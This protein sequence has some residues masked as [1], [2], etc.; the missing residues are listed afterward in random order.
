[1]L[2]A[3]LVATILI[4]L[5]E[6]GDKT[7]LLALVL[8]CRYKPGQVLLG[9]FGATLLIHLLSTLVGAAVGSFVPQTV[10]TW[11]AGLLFVGFGIWTLRGDSV[12]EDAE[13][14]PSRFGPVV[15]SGIAFF[16]AEM[17]DKTQIMTM[18]I[19]A[20]PG[21]ALRTFGGFASGW[22]PAGLAESHGPW[23][24]AGV[25][26]GS[27]LGMVIADGLAILVGAVLGK[28]LPEK[29]ITRISGVLFIIF[30]VALVASVFLH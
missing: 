17:G 3:F 15:T 4:T 10:L 30:G 29:L 11:A 8:A 1:V 24:L 5:A 14:P 19:A 2:Y 18:T 16:L 22:L 9:I 7:Q 21:A 23:M 20:S 26:L 12:D 6:L 28:K 25:W 27:T 13:A